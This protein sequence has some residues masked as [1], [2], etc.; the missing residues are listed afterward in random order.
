MASPRGISRGKGGYRM[1]LCVLSHLPTVLPYTFTGF[2]RSRDLEGRKARW[3]LSNDQR[4]RVFVAIIL[5]VT[6]FG[7][8]AASRWVS[9][10]IDSLEA[11]LGEAQAALLEWKDINCNGIPEEE[12]VVV[13]TT[14][15]P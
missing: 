14:S 5:G 3:H 4:D 1:G 11:Y 7:S 13:L 6:R 12:E 8:V 15:K 9:Y 10:N 2:Q